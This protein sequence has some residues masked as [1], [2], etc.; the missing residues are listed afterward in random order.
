MAQEE[1][2]LRSLGVKF[3]NQG[4]LEYMPQRTLEAI[5]GHR[6][7]P[8]YRSLVA[9]YTVSTPWGHD[10]SQAE[11]MADPMSP[12]SNTA[13]N[14]PAVGSPTQVTRVTRDPTPSPPP[15]P[16]EVDTPTI[17]R[18]IP[19]ATIADFEPL[20]DLGDEVNDMTD[21]Q[22]R[23]PLKAAIAKQA[24]NA[25]IDPELLLYAT[26]SPHGADGRVQETIDSD[27]LG[28]CPPAE[29]RGHRVRPRCQEARNAH[30]RRRAEYACAI[31]WRGTI[32]PRS[33]RELS[34]LG[35]TQSDLMLLCVRTIE[36]GHKVVRHFKRSTARGSGV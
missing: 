28:L 8:D 14:A 24:E 17:L 7:R 36:L 35:L 20:G 27:L 34:A 11:G 16:P 22:W 15:P 4:L 30:A 12:S 23:G 19:N 9:L 5:K 1:A 3:L 32:A 26:Q 2:R 33:A 29:G 21:Y 10:S 6:R 31:N 18:P 13:G 25:L